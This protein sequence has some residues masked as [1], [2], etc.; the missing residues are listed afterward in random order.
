MDNDSGDRSVQVQDEEAV[1]QRCSVK[2]VFLEISQNSQ[3]NTCARDSFLIKLQASGLFFI[4]KEFLPQVFSCAFC[5][6]SKN[7]F[8][9]RTPPVAASEDGENNGSGEQSPI[10]VSQERH[11]NEEK[12][13]LA[14]GNQG[15]QSRV[16]KRKKKSRKRKVSASEEDSDSS[17]TDFSS[18][19]RKKKK[20]KRRQHHQPTL[21]CSST[22]SDSSTDEES[23]NYRFKI[24]TENEKIPKS[25]AK[26]TQKYG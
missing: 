13:S 9:Y 20:A 23:H 16:T 25:M 3:E 21:S 4:K 7:T 2:K 10:H 26:I 18:P 12:D 14:N 11:R 8:F 5:E 1:A 17:S 15:S 19:A 24:I 6:I 22:A